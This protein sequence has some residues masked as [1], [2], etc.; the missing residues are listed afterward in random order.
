VEL[1]SG[2]L[3]V[4]QSRPG[5]AVAAAERFLT[6]HDPTFKRRHGFVLTRYARALTI[7]KEIPEAASRLTEAAAITRQHSSARLA[8][9]INQAR[10]RLQ[11]WADTTYVRQLDETLRSCGLN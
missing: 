6:G 2:G 3:S 11:P 7:A 4:R 8:E 10:A 9:E 5:P 1:L